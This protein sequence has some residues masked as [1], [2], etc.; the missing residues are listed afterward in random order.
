MLM[1]WEQ[2]A[3]Y[4]EALTWNRGICISHGWNTDGKKRQE[5]DP[6]KKKTDVKEMTWI[7]EHRALETQIIKLFHIQKEAIPVG[8]R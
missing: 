6:R 5:I 1:P 2:V 3:R 8:G 4:E 7:A